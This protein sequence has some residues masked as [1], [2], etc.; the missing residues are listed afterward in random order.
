MEK[1]CTQCGRSDVE[2]GKKAKNKD[3]L[4]S[5]CKG[6]M[7]LIDH[8][9]KKDNPG[10]AASRQKAWRKANPEK[11]KAKKARL[12]W[13]QKAREAGVSFEPGVEIT[14]VQKIEIRQKLALKTG[15]VQGSTRVM[16]PAE[17]EVRTKL[18][19][20]RQQVTS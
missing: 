17:L 19:E 9:I 4:Q 6:C 7:A 15:R 13:H 3:G 20:T 16:G 11:A 14:E 1:H 10:A 8:A 18:A 12:Y 2:F 5:M